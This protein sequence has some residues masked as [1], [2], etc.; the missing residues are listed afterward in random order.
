MSSFIA[1]EFPGDGKPKAVALPDPASVV[2]VDNG[3][4]CINLVSLIEIKLAS[5]MTAN[6]GVADLGD[7]IKLAGILNLGKSFAAQLNPYVRPKFE[8]LVIREQEVRKYKL[9]R[10]NK[11][12]MV[13]VNSIHELAELEANASVQLLVMKADGVILEHGESAEYW[14]FFTNDPGVAA[15]YDTHDESEFID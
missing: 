4:K 6:D 2:Q 3:L 9:L 13:K 8:E 5:G 10:E 15:K 14:W 11:K 7:V 12:S 1:G